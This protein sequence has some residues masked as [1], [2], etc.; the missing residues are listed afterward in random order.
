MATKTDV[1]PL[2]ELI[3]S[4]DKADM[5]GNTNIMQMQTQTLE[6]LLHVPVVACTKVHAV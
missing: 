5:V 2:G 4:T 3:S 6:W 1:S